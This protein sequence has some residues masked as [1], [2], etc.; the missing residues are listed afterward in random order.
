MKIDVFRLGR[1]I[2]VSIRDDP[3]EGF[4][5]YGLDLPAALD[6]L[7]LDLRSTPMPDESPARAQLRR[8]LSSLSGRSLRR[9]LGALQ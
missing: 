9:R 1:L 6:G 7:I 2:G 8:D 4:S 5:G 3:A